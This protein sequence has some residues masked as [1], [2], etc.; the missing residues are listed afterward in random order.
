MS[1]DQRSKS[2]QERNNSRSSIKISLSTSSNQIGG[3]SMRI[4]QSSKEGEERNLKK[5]L[6]RKEKARLGSR[7][8]HKKKVKGYQRS[9]N[10]NNKKKK[11]DSSISSDKID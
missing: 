8:D 1:I 10:N 7:F 6:R 5:M 9:N 4:G 3:S 11:K 2:S